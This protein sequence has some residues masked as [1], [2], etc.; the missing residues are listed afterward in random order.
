MPRKKITKKQKTTKTKARKTSVVIRK[1]IT[2]EETHPLKKAFRWGESYTSLLL[3]IIVVIIG[4]LFFAS[5][6]KTQHKTQEVSSTSTVVTPV[7]TNISAEELAKQLT[8]IPS[9]TP[10]ED[11]QPT[12]VTPTTAP[13]KQQMKQPQPTQQKI[14][15]VES[16]EGL[17]QIAEKV[18]HNGYQWVVI[19][20][21][22]NLQNP[23]LIFK[24]D[25]LIIPTITAIPTPQIAQK[26]TLSPPAPAQQPES[27]KSKTYTVQKGDDLWNI[28]VRAYGDGYRWVDIARANNLANP[29][30]IFSGN[31]L[32]LPR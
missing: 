12:A 5:I 19:A 26:P 25:K 2:R 24:G 4:F 17:W 30:L 29:G 23:E 6:I 9:I 13:E 11:K 18:Y 3:G 27:I 22:N 20:R 32:Q 15:T 10:I 21:A 7:P 14:Y 8:G 1:R 31:V 28:A 16:G